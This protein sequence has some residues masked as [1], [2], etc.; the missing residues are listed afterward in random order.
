M[1]LIAEAKRIKAIHPNYMILYKSGEFYKAFG[2]DAY[3][4]SYLCDYRIKIIENNV[5]ICGF[6]V[7]TIYKVRVKIEEKNINYMLIDPRNNY[8][9]DVIEDFKNLNEYEKQFE[10]SYNIAKCKKKIKNI[11]NKLTTLIEYP[12]FKEIVRKVDEILNETGKV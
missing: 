2:K 5:A 1:G 11:E 8:Q 9:V 4:L 3:I 6:P 12:N 7:S 10:K